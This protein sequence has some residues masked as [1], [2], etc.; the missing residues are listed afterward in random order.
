MK[1]LVS[2]LMVLA[3]AAALPFGLT[4]CA[5][6]KDNSSVNKA[7]IKENNIVDA[8][9]G[10]LVG[11]YTGT[12]QMP[13][14]PNDVSLVIYILSQ[15][16]TNTD[17][18]PGIKKVP[19]AHLRLVSPRVADYYLTLGL[20]SANTSNFSMTNTTTPQLDDVSSI[21][22]QVNGQNIT[23]IVKAM[24]GTLGTLNVQL[25]SRET[26]ANNNGADE[27]LRERLNRIYN[28]VA[29]E[30][31]GDIVNGSNKI[32]ISITLT[33]FNMAN[34]YPSLSGF[35]KRLDAP[36][37]VID[38][39][40]NVEY[41]PNTNPP[42]ITMDGHGS[43]TYIISITGVLVNDQIVADIT[44]QHVGYMGKMILNKKKK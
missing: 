16:I 14:G 35:Y 13:N 40:L 20:S 25:S 17:G 36:E 37:G 12:L 34:Q 21:D 22:A 15:P 7:Q 38:L 44:S 9:Y 42:R 8:V 24:T 4:G 11:T 23:G 39:S 27:D 30:Y 28:A 3:T 10:P 18:T 43:G 31:T 29:G 19:Y 32:P 5:F 2:S 26:E 41:N 1:L 33:V 6:G